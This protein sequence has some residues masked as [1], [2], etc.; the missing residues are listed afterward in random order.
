MFK[1]HEI[2]KMI[3]HTLLHPALTDKEIKAGCDVAKKYNVAAVT[4]KPYIIREVAECLQGTDIKVASVV[5]FPHGSSSPEIKMLEAQQCIKDGATEIEI[6][7]NIGRVL[8][9]NRDYTEAELSILQQ[10]VS[11]HNAIMKVVIESD[12]LT[13]DQHKIY[14]C[15][16]CNKLNVPYINTST[17][18]GFA[19]HNNGFYRCNG[20]TEHVKLLKMH[21]AESINIKTTGN[22]STLDDLLRFKELGVSRI[23]TTATQTIMDEAHK[24]YGE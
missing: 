18:F 7:I 24:R 11:D 1:V 23:G 10:I 20:A 2:A 19:Q 17:G 3:D 9:E 14:L 21:A 16:V 5:G 12:F 22:I 13:S 15:E 8:S 4:V 6:V